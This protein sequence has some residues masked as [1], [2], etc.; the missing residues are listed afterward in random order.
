M[1]P[2][3]VDLFAPVGRIAIDIVGIALAAKR[4]RGAAL[5]RH[6]AVGRLESGADFAACATVLHGRDVDALVAA[7]LLVGATGGE[8]A[9]LADAVDTGVG[10]QVVAGDAGHATSTTLPIACP[11]LADAARAAAR[12]K[13]AVT[14]AGAA[15]ARFTRGADLAARA[16]V[17][18][19]GGGIDA[20]LAALDCA[21]LA[22]LLLLL[23]L[24]GVYLPSSVAW[25]FVGV[26][27][28]LLLVLATLRACSRIGFT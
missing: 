1:I 13:G 19:V 5:A 18:A 10:L 3:R 26:M 25:R 8:N 2:E 28:V 12:A 11:G 16:A 17:R 9:A 23:L 20:N 24:F 27:A 4:A 14:G 6:I 22:L 7:A 21:A 15:L